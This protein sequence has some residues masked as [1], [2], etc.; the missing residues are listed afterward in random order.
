MPIYE[1]YCESCRKSIELL[2]DI[3]DP[4]LDQCPECHSAQFSKK[5]SVS[6]FKLTGSGWYETDFKGSKSSGSSKSSDG[7]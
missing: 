4:V 3:D 7:K 6:S 5:V 1:Y 2:Q